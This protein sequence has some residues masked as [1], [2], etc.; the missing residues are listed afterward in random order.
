M[1]AAE[2]QAAEPGG[3][4]TRA[5]AIEELAR[6]EEPEPAAAEA[7]PRPRPAEPEPDWRADADAALRERVAARSET[8]AEGAARRPP[9]FVPTLST[10]CG[11]SRGS[12]R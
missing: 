12:S 6:S 7:E 10:A 4:C 11:L 8:R 5:R 9:R 3:R 2:R 1:E